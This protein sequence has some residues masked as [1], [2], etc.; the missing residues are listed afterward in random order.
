MPAC[1]KAGRVKQ[2]V[3][4]LESSGVPFELRLRLERLQRVVADVGEKVGAR[5]S[6]GGF[7]P[8]LPSGCVPEFRLGE[9]PS[10]AFTSKRV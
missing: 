5:A 7:G 3:S 1:F 2:R 8:S 6:S 10:H 9:L 4:L